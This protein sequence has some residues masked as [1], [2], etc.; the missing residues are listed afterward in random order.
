MSEHGDAQQILVILILA[1][2]LV[3]LQH[4]SNI[5]AYYRE[6]AKDEEAHKEARQAQPKEV[7]CSLV[8]WLGAH[9]P[10]QVLDALCNAHP[11]N[12]PD[13]F[14]P[15]GRVNPQQGSH[16]VQRE[17]LPKDRPY[18]HED[19]GWLVERARDAQI[20][21][22]LC[23]VCTW[24]RL[25]IKVSIHNPFLW[26]CPSVYQWVVKDDH[27]CEET[28]R[29]EEDVELSA[30]AGLQD[31]AK[32]LTVLL[33]FLVECETHDEVDDRAHHSHGHL[34]EV[35]LTIHVAD[36]PNIEH[37]ECEECPQHTIDN[38]IGLVVIL[39][40]VIQ[41]QVGED[42][43]ECECGRWGRCKVK[44]AVSKGR[45]FGIVPEGSSTFEEELEEWH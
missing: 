25:F 21:C 18:Q 35:V 12:G 44:L 29:K 27:G 13:N 37:D 42:E 31:E 4:K 33:Q 5:L 19:Y 10:E 9:P 23:A 36:E 41:D 45:D 22:I 34:E 8:I 11:N 17:G 24:A 15:G 20:G 39:H 6:D 14:L 43:S 40:E 1:L 38:N 30:P 7:L 32:L 26:H 16:I 3:W 2:D 28:Q